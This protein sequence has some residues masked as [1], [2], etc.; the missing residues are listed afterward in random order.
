MIRLMY[1]CFTLLIPISIG[2]GIGI[3]FEREQ[4]RRECAFGEGQWTGTICV[5]SELLQ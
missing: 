3:W 1:R 2:V 5:N 4:M